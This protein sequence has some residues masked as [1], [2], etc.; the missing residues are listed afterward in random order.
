MLIWYDDY[1]M[2][3]RSL[4]WECYMRLSWVLF[5]FL[6]SMFPPLL[7][8]QFVT[9]NTYQGKTERKHVVVISWVWLCTVQIILEGMGRAL[10]TN[11][12]ARFKC[13]AL[14]VWLCTF[15]SMRMFVKSRSH[16]GPV[17]ELFPTDMKFELNILPHWYPHKQNQYSLVNLKRRKFSWLIARCCRPVR[18]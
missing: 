14:K 6:Y 1:S 4:L 11:F 12:N 15:I 10:H 17:L 7:R 2:T 8:E 3:E 16:A 5:C 18:V 13:E 9:I